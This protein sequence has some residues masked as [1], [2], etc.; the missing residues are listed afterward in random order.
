MLP[1]TRGTAGL[2]N[3]AGQ[4]IGI[5]NLKIAQQGVEGLG[6][7]I[8]VNDTKPIINDLIRNGN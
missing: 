4:L 6:F 1:L 2:V 3:V 8:P 5:N 7:A